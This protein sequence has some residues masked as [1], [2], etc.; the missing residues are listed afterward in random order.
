MNGR[1]Y[2]RK[3]W[4]WSNLILIALIAIAFTAAFLLEHQ[5]PVVALVVFLV[6]F[7]SLLDTPCPFCGKHLIVPPGTKGPSH[8]K[9]CY[10]CGHSLDD[11]I[12][13]KHDPSNAGNGL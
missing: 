2:I 13:E 4:W 6:L 7:R 12:E 5:W 11:N 9:Y 8:F 10:R 3:K 1:D